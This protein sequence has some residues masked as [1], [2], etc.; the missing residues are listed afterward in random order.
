MPALSS[1][2][3]LATLLPARVTVEVQVV[4]LVD[5]VTDVVLTLLRTPVAT[6]STQGPSWLP[7]PPPA[8]SGLRSR[9][10][11]EIGECLKV[12]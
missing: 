3:A 8:L 4:V 6:D 12:L 9:V 1:Q 2:A 11:R 10:E 5:R 7:F